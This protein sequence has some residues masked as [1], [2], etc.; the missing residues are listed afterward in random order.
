MRLTA[1]IGV[2]ETTAVKLNTDFDGAM[3]YIQKNF[4]DCNKY[5]RI[6]YETYAG[7]SRRLSN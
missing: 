7:F 2:I 6:A 3:Q 4:N 5:Q 1:A